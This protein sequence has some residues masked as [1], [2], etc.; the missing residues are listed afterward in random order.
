LRKFENDALKV[1]PVKNS[2]SLWSAHDHCVCCCL[3]RKSIQW[4]GIIEILR[5]WREQDYQL[6]SANQSKSPQLRYL[7]KIWPTLFYKNHICFF[8][9]VLKK[10]YTAPIQHVWRHKDFKAQREDQ[11][12]TRLPRL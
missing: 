8:L 6:P 1:R 9:S 10:K 12:A 2:K 11:F 7:T 3:R 4:H 5:G